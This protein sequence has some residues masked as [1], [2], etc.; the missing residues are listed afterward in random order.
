MLSVIAGHLSNTPV[1]RV[2]FAYHLTVFFIL[3]GYTL[4]AE[5]TTE[6]LG[7]RFRSL[8]I[9][10]FITCAGIVVMDVVN[11][12]VL[13]DITAMGTITKSVAKNLL[14][15]FMASGTRTNF[16]T[17]EIGSMIGA[18]WFLPAM[19]F[20]VVTAQLLLTKV[21]D[22]RN[23]YLIGCLLSVLSHISAQFLWLPFSIQ[24]GI[25]VAP[26]LL[27]GYD[28]RRCNLLEKIRLPHFI[29][30]LS[31]F[32]VGIVGGLT[33]IYFVTT[34][35][36]DL[37]LSTVVTLCAAGAVIYLA[38][39]AEKCSF[40]GWIGRNS[41]Y[42]LCV[43]AFDMAVMS[44]WF[45]SGLQLLGL[46]YTG[47]VKF[48]VRLVFALTVTALLLWKKRPA[49]KQQL[50]QRNPALDVAKGFLIALMILG[51]FTIDP[52]LR[53][54]IYSFHM[55][56]FIFYSG[57]CYR[58]GRPLGSYLLKILRGALIPYLVFGVFYV[59]LMDLGTQQEL[60]NL[61]L[62]MSF[63]RAVFK[64]VDSIGPVYFILMLLLTKVIYTL[65]DKFLRREVWLFGAVLMLSMAGVGLAKLGMWLPWSL[66]C[67]LYSL[68][69][70]YLG[71][72]CKEY[73]FM[74]YFLRRPWTYFLLT[75]IWVYMIYQGGMEI[76]IR[77]Y[78]HYGVVVIGAVCACVLL[79]Q[80]C[81]YL[82]ESLPRS[83]L[84]ILC[85]VGE[86]TL[87]ILI[88]HRLL[89]S[90]INEF[91]CRWLTPGYLW[92]TAAMVTIQLLLGT[93]IALA[94]GQTKKHFGNRL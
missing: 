52:S 3:S 19:F 25:F 77:K 29:L 9:P 56:A 55:A 8:M 93:L 94:V 39:K 67:A 53:K 1:N 12:V 24:A 75:P 83:M 71:A 31:V 62:S 69:F 91:L 26:F 63:S 54:I 33:K 45:R 90:R 79:Y 74:D 5:L 23:R 50:S 80:L 27:L 61:L 10:Y 86:S 88:I 18:I 2:V 70:Y 30:C 41:I 60:K 11:L 65:L 15:S 36:S 72:K 59:L 49:K 13:D 21:P 38:K 76:A 81:V 82:S 16:G 73:K 66:D 7:K 4:K 58:S 48:L 68:I 64:T 51:H 47:I 46:E 22:Q 6:S 87:Y 28:L 92:H 78:N 35:V 84:R 42:F 43:H 20:A 85:S 44:R 34:T 32:L 37:I 17:I 14:I 57:F 89:N 40:L